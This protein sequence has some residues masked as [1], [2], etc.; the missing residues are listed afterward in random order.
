MR[1]IQSAQSSTTSTR[2]TME[3][4]KDTD[5]HNYAFLNSHSV[6]A[7]IHKI[8]PLFTPVEFAEFRFVRSFFAALSKKEI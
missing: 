2:M 7:K 6:V 3:S 1:S 8:K 4:K 5:R